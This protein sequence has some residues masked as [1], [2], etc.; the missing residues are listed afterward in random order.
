[1]SQQT[2]DTDVATASP[3]GDGF[4]NVS[5]FVSAS[6]ANMQG[7]STANANA[8][9]DIGG[10]SRLPVVRPAAPSTTDNNR[11]NSNYYVDAAGFLRPGPNASAAGSPASE[12]E[13][14][15]PSCAVYSPPSM[16]LSHPSGVQETGW[17]QVSQM[18]GRYE[19]VY[20]RD[21]Q[22][23]HGR[24]GPH[25]G[26]TSASAYTAGVSRPG[27]YL[28]PHDGPIVMYCLQS[29]NS[30]SQS[31]FPALSSVLST[32]DSWTRVSVIHPSTVR[33]T[34]HTC[35]MAHGLTT[36]TRLKTPPC[37]RGMRRA[38][39]ALRETK[40]DMIKRT[41]NMLRRPTLTVGYTRL[42]KADASPLGLRSLCALLGLLEFVS[43]RQTHLLAAVSRWVR[44]PWLRTNSHG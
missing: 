23:I 5:P 20:G 24:H 43:S 21:A 9:A 39:H 3:G 33:P 13:A 36:N 12:V 1:M 41:M 34:N 4:A 32:Q 25:R 14:P 15:T 42:W 10:F 22:G 40:R 29:R 38:R 7:T 6:R 19:F 30:F 2:H 27:R 17:R 35:F 28:M 11:R 18:P 44:N 31:L 37:I 16:F 26:G 8:G